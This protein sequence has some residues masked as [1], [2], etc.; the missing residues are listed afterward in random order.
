MA[1]VAV[2]RFAISTGA[3]S[4]TQDVTITGFGTP[5]AVLFFFNKATT[6][7]TVSSGMNLGMGMTDGT[8]QYACMANSA[9]AVATTSGARRVDTSACILAIDMGAHG[10]KSSAAF[11]TWITDG[12]RLTITDDFPVAHEITAVFFSNSCTAAVSLEVVGSGAVSPSSITATDLG[13]EPDVVFGLGAN[14][15]VGG[16]I[17]FSTITYGVAVNDGGLTQRGTSYSDRDAVSTTQGRTLITK[18]NTV[19]QVA[20]N[21]DTVDWALSIIGFTSTGF[22]YQ[23]DSSAANDIVAFLAVKFPTGTQFKLQDTGVPTT[24]NIVLTGVGFQPYFG[25]SSH[26]PASTSW[27]T[28]ANTGIANNISM[29]DASTY[30]LVS[31][32]SETGLSSVSNTG[33]YIDSTF[34]LL[35]ADGTV[36]AD[37]SGYAFDSGGW[38]ITLTSNPTTETLGWALAVGESSGGTPVSFTGT[39]PTQNL[40]QSSAASIDV[41]GYFAGTETPFTYSLQSGTL[42][43]GL[44]LNTSTGV[45]S[46]TPTTVE[47]QAGIVI[48]ATDTDTATADTNSFTI[49][50]ATAIPTTVAYDDDFD[51][52]IG[53]ASVTSG[54]TTLTPVL[55][56]TPDDQAAVPGWLMTYCRFSG[57]LG[58]T[59]TFELSFVDWR[60]ANSIPA[61]PDWG[62]V[63]RYVDDTDPGTGR[64]RTWNEFTNNDTAYNPHGFSNSSAFTGDVIEVASK[65]R[66]RYKDTQAAIAYVAGHSSGYA[67]ELPSSVAATGEATHVH[68]S[69]TL[70]GTSRNTAPIVALNQYCIG[71]EDTSVS[72]DGGL[73]KLN[74][75]IFTGMHSSEDQGNLLAWSLVY[76]FLEDVSTQATWFRKHCKL[77]VYDVNPAGRYYGQERITE[78]EYDRDPNRVWDLTI[79]TQIEA[80][81]SALAL[82]ASTWDILFDCHGGYNLNGSGSAAR[83]G[84]FTNSSYPVK[85]AYFSRMNTLVGMLNFG[86]LDSGSAENYF[87]TILSAQ[88]STTM[89]NPYAAVGY[90]DQDTMYN[91]HATDMITVLSDML[92]ADELVLGGGLFADDLE[93][94]SEVGTPSIGQVHALLAGDLESGSEVGTPAIGQTHVL[95][96]GDLESGSEVGTPAIGQVHTL[97][98]NGLDAASEV[99]S[100][101]LGAAG[102]LFADDVEA[103]AEISTPAIGQVHALLADDI[104]AATEVGTPAAGIISV[105]SAS[106]LESASEV[107]TP[108]IGSPSGMYADD[109]EAASEVGTPAIGQLHVLTAVDLESAA[110]VGTPG[111]QGRRD[112]LADDIAS[113]SEVSTPALAVVHVLVPNSLES[114]SGVGTPVLGQIHHLHPVDGWAGSEVGTPALHQSGDVFAVSVESGTYVG[115]PVL[116]IV[117]TVHPNVGYEET[118]QEG[119]YAVASD[120]PGIELSSAVGYM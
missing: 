10:I 47:N 42:P 64:M 37:S 117:R 83:F 84:M 63:W 114:S 103:A 66:W 34:S 118:T 2:K 30:S 65:P 101:A 29:F 7:G 55:T 77:S 75:A 20:S 107:S 111:V 93:S 98:A 3:A 100:P 80:V 32:H 6:D 82:D 4:T 15:G 109:L 39:V 79:S 12:V 71:L 62:M 18:L 51:S 43:A 35:R 13:V 45:I 73:E 110:E 26:F 28:A 23:T 8:S 38:T 74:I 69:E 97:L 92:A 67:Y 91:G 95:L 76:M 52:A 105:L 22:T 58:K 41:S 16:S 120:Q 113:A 11:N 106:D 68:H 88:L 49:D 115:T 90:P 116:R 44:S 94:G 36:D 89:E 9:D 57:V 87:D 33:D 59:P 27:D 104:D 31:G 108:A 17:A 81:K 48:R 53:T 14:Q 96:A 119:G 40:T 85:A 50:V 46:G 99:G 56:M 60:I 25:L 54:A 19:G 24:G 61:D 78:E 102:S 70:I 5:S 112:L 86:P 21:S 72:P 1:H